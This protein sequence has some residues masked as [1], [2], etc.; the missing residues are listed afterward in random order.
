LVIARILALVG[1]G[2]FAVVSGL[3][4]HDSIVKRTPSLTF[5]GLG[6]VGIIFTVMKSER[7]LTSLKSIARNILVDGN[8]GL[9][10][11]GI[12]FIGT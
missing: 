8:W 2:L 4:A 5:I 10:W 9:T 1:F 11:Y 3:K 12:F 6:L 7:L